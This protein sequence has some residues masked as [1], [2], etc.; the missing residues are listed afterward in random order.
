[1]AQLNPPPRKPRNLDRR[2]R[3]HL[4]PH[5]VE[6]L[7]T[8]AK[9]IGRHGH[10]DGALILLAFSHGFRVNELVNLRWDQVDLR[11]GVLHVWRLKNGQPSTHPLRGK[12]L[13]AL[14]K[15]ARDYPETQYVFVSER[16]GP[17]TDSAVRKIVARA[18]EEAKLGMP[19]HPHQL[20]HSCGF[21]LANK[22]VDTR[23]IQHYLG[24]NN[25]QHTVRY[26]ALAPDRFKNFWS[27]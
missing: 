2:S 12:E 4:F 17:L 27:D 6:S 16:R 19:V 15:L 5:E 26:T 3:E 18:G 24:H 25:I 11:Q 13:R 9:K 8:A 1:M 7:I 23:A 20:R 10:R 21:Y 22:G 14:R